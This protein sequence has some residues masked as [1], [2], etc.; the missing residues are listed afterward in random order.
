MRNG[1]PDFQPQRLV[2]ARDS[3]SF[4]QTALARLIGRD[5]ST[6]SKWEKGS[7]SPE[8]EALEAIS[9][10]LNVPIAYF[11]QEMTEHGPAPLFFRS[12]ASTTSTLRKQ[13]RARLRWAQNISLHLQEWLE[14]PVVNV[15]RLDVS[16]HKEI[17]DVDIEE[18]ANKCRDE[19]NLGRGPISN[20]LLVMENAGIIVVKDETGSV[21]MDGLSNW[22]SADGRP[23][24]LIASDKDA[25]VR[26]RMDAA[27]ELGHLVLHHNINEGTLRKSS[28]FKEIERQAFYF[29][30]AFLMPEESF[31]MEI[32][33]PSLNSF[34]AMKERWK[35]SIGAMI[36][37]FKNLNLLSEEHTLRLWKAYSARGWR[38]SEPLDDS[39]VL[40]IEIPRLLSRSI[41]LLF[42]EGVRSKEDMLTDFRL[43]SHDVEKLC[44]LPNGYMN[45]FNA[46]IITMPKL[47]KTMTTDGT[48]TVVPFKKNN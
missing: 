3:S 15:P 8:P 42:D 34:L 24:V 17:R 39:N 6:I 44:S 12:M 19:W 22:S 25:C 31:P 10:A 46:E 14:M 47:K 32:R 26:S 37:R 20:L 45:D 33:T 48:G 35:V 29:A 13:T 11:M 28:D 1:T 7:Q 41:R 36:M 2:E 40:P 21:K 16:D 43:Q 4:T 9:K 27:H 18:I 5:S 23:Y 30:G 38:K